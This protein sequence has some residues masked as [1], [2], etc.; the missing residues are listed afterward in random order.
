MTAWAG[1]LALPG[2]DLSFLQGVTSVAVFRVL[3][4]LLLGFPGAL[5]LSRALSGWAGRRYNPQTGL[6]VGKLVLYPLLLALLTSVLVLLGVSLTPLLGAAGVLGIAIGFAS[7]TSVSNIISGFFLI[8]EQP[9]VVD[10]V[11]QVGSTTGRVLSV[12]TMS[13]QLRTFDNRFVRIPNETLIKSEVVNL[14]RFPIRRMD[15]RVGIEY[16]CDPA[17]ASDVLLRIARDVPGI[18][19]EPEPRVWFE[20]FGASSVDL[21]LSAWAE[22]DRHWELK[23]ELQIR[24]KKGLEEDGI[25][26]AFPHQVLVPSQETLRVQLVE[27]EEPGGHGAEA[28]APAPDQDG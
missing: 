6:V 4:L 12:G 21:R 16:R 3:L 13:V 14:T 26:I 9:F 11:I 28:D 5:L 7:Q 18:L 22:T 20:G 27:P 24:V 23:N 10:D 15:V 25:V 8:G 2:Q 17:V 19:M 1:V